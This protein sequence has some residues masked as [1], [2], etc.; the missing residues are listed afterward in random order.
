LA[1]ALVFVASA[2]AKQNVSE[3][4]QADSEHFT[5]FVGLLTALYTPLVIGVALTGIV[6]IVAS[7][8]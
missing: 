2:I 3:L 4:I 8:E 6:S 1:A 5:E 7:S